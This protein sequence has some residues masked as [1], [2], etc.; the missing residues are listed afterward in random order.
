M[1]SFPE[2]NP[3]RTKWQQPGQAGLGRSLLPCGVSADSKSTGQ[4]S[5]G[6]PRDELL[7]RPVRAD[8]RHGRATK[9]GAD[10]FRGISAQ[11][12]E[13]CYTGLRCRGDRWEGSL[14]HSLAAQV[15]DNG[16]SRRGAVAVVHAA[17]VAAAVVALGGCAGD[18][19]SLVPPPSGTTRAVIATSTLSQSQAD[20]LASALTSVDPAISSQ[21]LVPELAAG[22]VRSGTQVL[23]AGTVLHRGLRRPRRRAGTSV[24]ACSH[25]RDGA[26]VLD[27]HPVPSEREMACA[28]GGSEMNRLALPFAAG[29][30]RSTWFARSQKRR[31]AVALRFSRALAT[32]T[33]A[34]FVAVLSSTG[35]TASAGERSG[36]TPILG[37]APTAAASC[38]TSI[39]TRVPIILVH[40]F[41][42]SASTWDKS[43]SEFGTD[44]R[45]C[46][47]RFDYATTSTLWV[48]DQHNAP[49]LAK[50]IRDL[51]DRSKA[52]GGAGKVIVV[53]HSLG[54]LLTL[55]ASSTACVGQGAVPKDVL[56]DVITMGTPLHGTFLK[57]YGASLVVDA[58]GALD[59]LTSCRYVG[60]PGLC[61]EFKAL[62]SS[63]AAAAFTPG[64]SQLKSMPPWPNEV[65]VYA[66]AGSLRL[67]AKVFTYTQTIG[68]VGDAVVSEESALAGSHPVGSLG[69]REVVDCGVVGLRFYSLTP[70]AVIT[71][72]SSAFDCW[73]GIETYY[74]GF[75]TVAQDEIARALN[76]IQ[77]GLVV[78]YDAEFWIANGDKRIAACRMKADGAECLDWA[79][80]LTSAQNGCSKQTDV[81]GAAIS[82]NHSGWWCHGGPAEAAL[83][84][85]V[86]QT[87]ATRWALG[88]DYPQLPGTWGE[89]AGAKAVLPP[90]HT[91]IRGPITCTA[92]TAAIHCQNVATGVWFTMSSSGLA[93]D[94]K[95]TVG[96]TT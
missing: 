59:S 43:V 19:P 71:P 22:V 92:Q 80:Y 77:P 36:S 21:V 30:P 14:G 15:L 68:D 81:V 20:A 57:G 63:P 67:Q 89:D 94:G 61:E 93:T 54:G 83:I 50:V 70:N 9:V 23:P 33:A 90:G 12:L 42:S 5:D 75:I 13:S 38:G 58:L 44:L 86:V 74:S 53:A 8:W 64:S 25:D 73:H 82:A 85:G 37:A 10:G 28:V 62:E 40:G 88:H 7:V 87:S 39:G 17:V 1:P 84:L 48:D 91:L 96:Q 2:V 47:F 6:L 18:A 41:T 24:R 16:S 79:G 35:S 11:R 56:L 26:W 3:V 32:V 52:A 66:I 34:L 76:S 60:I 55:C 45:T 78:D 72:D 65:P 27:R 69:G 49:A 46:V 95:V 4:P 31:R 29:L 51:G